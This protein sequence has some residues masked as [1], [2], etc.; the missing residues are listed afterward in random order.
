MLMKIQGNR[1]QPCIALIFI[2]LHI[3]N[4]FSLHRRVA[5]E[6]HTDA[7]V[8]VELCLSRLVSYSS[9]T[10][11][12]TLFFHLVHIVHNL[13]LV[14]TYFLIFSFTFV[15]IPTSLLLQFCFNFHLTFLHLPF[16]SNSFHSHTPLLSF[17]SFICDSP[18][19]S[20]KVN[21]FIHSS[22]AIFFI[23]P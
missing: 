18:H 16:I 19:V 20:P 21:R 8:F 13:S 3:L 17:L 4:S 15:S 11:C 23:L 7:I 12:H 14:S 5:Y 2:N 9:L 22:G 6:P 1:S 10:R